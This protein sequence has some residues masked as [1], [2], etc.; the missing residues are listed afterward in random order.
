MQNDR[1]LQHLASGLNYTQVMSITG[2]SPTYLK[3]LLEDAEFKTALEEA[4]LTHVETVSEEATINNKYLA[5]EHGILKQVETA[6]MTA[7]LRDLT[8]LLRVVNERSDK[9]AS[10]KHAAE[11]KTEKVVNQ[12]ILMMP[13]HT[14]P[15]YVVSGAK[16]IVAIGER[17]LSPMNSGN[18]KV[19]FQNMKENIKDV[20]SVTEVQEAA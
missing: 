8:N 17:A 12:V 11:N 18:V 1:I 4:K 10:R 3:A 14:M 13:T 5:I 19:L 2:A 9:L 16:E 20:S 7:E 6:M 15:E